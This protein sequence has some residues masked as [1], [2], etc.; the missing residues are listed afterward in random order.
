[1]AALCVAAV[2]APCRAP[3]PVMGSGGGCEKKSLSLRPV[4]V[5]YSCGTLFRPSKRPWASFPRFLARLRGRAGSGLR[6]KG[7]RPVSRWH[8]QRCSWRPSPWPCLPAAPMPSCFATARRPS[9]KGPHSTLFPPRC[10]IPRHLARERG[11]AS[12]QVDSDSQEESRVEAT[13]SISLPAFPSSF[14]SRPAPPRQPI[15]VGMKAGGGR[16]T[17]A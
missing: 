12:C 7:R 11:A 16:R 13:L 9:R 14:P 6:G 2:A 1:M 15:E 4:G 3:P 10:P 17:A 8:L 5:L